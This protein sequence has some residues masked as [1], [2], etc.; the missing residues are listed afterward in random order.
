MNGVSRGNLLPAQHADGVLSEQCVIRPDV[1]RLPVEALPLG[2]AYLEERFSNVRFSSC[3]TEFSSESLKS[4]ACRCAVARGHYSARILL[5]LMA[6]VKVFISYSNKDQRWLDRL[7]VHL[8]PIEKSGNIEVW[9]DTRIKPGENWAEEIEAA[10]SQCDIALLLISADFLASDFITSKELPP[11][12]QAA[13]RHACNVLSI[14][15]GPCM[16]SLIHDLQRF[17]A[18]NSPGRPLVKMKRAEAEEILAR[19]ARLIFDCVPK[20]QAKLAR[21]LRVIRE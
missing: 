10:L 11:L 9:A 3:A 13:S 12:L 6:M 8:R 16:F 14:I 7:L 20:Q 1:N 2:I 19:V 17:Q 4:R 18:L 5:G 21:D 15:I